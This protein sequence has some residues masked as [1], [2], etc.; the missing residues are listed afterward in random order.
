MKTI[1]NVVMLGKFECTLPVIDEAI[2]DFVN[3]LDKSFGKIYV[4]QHLNCIELL[5]SSKTDCISL[6]I[7]S[8]SF[9]KS[10]LFV[11]YDSI[12]ERVRLSEC[13]YSCFVNYFVDSNFYDYKNLLSKEN[14]ERVFN[15]RQ[16]LVKSILNNENKF[17]NV[18]KFTK[19]NIINNKYVC[20]SMFEIQ[21][22]FLTAIRGEFEQ[23][24]KVSI[25]K[26]S[27]D[28]SLKFTNEE[29]KV[30]NTITTP[31]NSYKTGDYDWFAVNWYEGLVANKSKKS[32]KQSQKLNSKQ[33]KQKSLDYFIE[34]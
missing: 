11:M 21:A 25:S 16:E 28:N 18:N 9:D 19:N 8:T 30:L 6:I 31:E 20:K 15:L 26:N 3:H 5:A 14:E 4:I 13:R 33:N 22:N 34:R 12:C 32:K 2:I 23:S 27:L 1:F 24:G 29:K 17:V 7:D 10:I